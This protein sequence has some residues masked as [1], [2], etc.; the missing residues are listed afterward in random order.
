VSRSWR[1]TAWTARHIGDALGAGEG[2]AGEQQSGITRAILDA[3]PVMIAVKTKD[4]RFE[5]V[6]SAFADFVGLPAEEIVGRTTFTSSG[7]GSGAQAGSAWR[8][9]PNRKSVWNQLVKG[10]DSHS[11]EKAI[12]AP[13]TQKSLSG[14]P[15]EPSG[16]LSYI[17]DV[18]ER[19]RDRGGR[20]AGERSAVQAHVSSIRRGDGAGGA[21][22]GDLPFSPRV[23]TRRRSCHYV[24][25][26]GV[27]TR[28]IRSSLW[29]R[30]RT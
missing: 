1:F 27:Y 8:G 2:G 30:F 12:W 26:C 16:T 10:R 19:V 9:D 15:M 22:A 20:L 25:S 17:V 14:N 3:A 28:E 11:A 29:Q 23:T 13:V 21:S 5:R 18:D 4:D 6:N 7:T 24:M